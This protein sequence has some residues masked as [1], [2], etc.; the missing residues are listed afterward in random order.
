MN[1]SIASG[2]SAAGDAGALDHGGELGPGNAGWH[3]AH[4]HC[5]AEATVGAGDHSLRSDDVD[6]VEQ[7]FG[8]QL[9]VLDEVGDGVDDAGNECHV[10]RYG[11]ALEDLPLVRVTRV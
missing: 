1:F 2:R 8:D 6:E 3:A 7:P 10:F 11:D 4:P 5:R 9:R